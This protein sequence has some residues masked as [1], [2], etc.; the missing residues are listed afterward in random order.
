MAL[1]FNG[2]SA[3]LERAGALATAHPVTLFAWIKPTSNSTTRGVL[4]VGASGTTKY[5]ALI[6]VSGTTV[7]AQTGN[8]GGSS[9][10]AAI[11]GLLT[12]WQPVLARFSAINSR[13]VGRGA[14]T[15]VGGSSTIDSEISTHDLFR[16]GDWTSSASRIWFAG[17]IAE[18]AAW[19]I[20]LTQADYDALAAGA[21]PETIQPGSLIDV[22][23][24]ETQAS[25]QVGIV[26][27]L[28]LTATDTSQ[29]SDHPITRSGG[30]AGVTL[31]GIASAEAFGAL[32]FSTGAAGVVLT[33][34]ASAEAFGSLSVSAGVTGQVALT[35]IASTE[36]F[37]SPAVGGYG[38]D[39]SYE[40]R[41]SAMG[42]TATWPRAAF[43][44]G[45]TYAG[46]V[47]TSNGSIG[48]T[49]IDHNGGDAI[50]T[51][52]I[53]ASFQNNSHACPSVHFLPDNR[54]ICLYSMHND[55]TGLRYNISTNPLD[56]SAW[57]A[58]GVMTAGG[59]VAY[60]VMHYLATP[61]KYFVHY[62]VSVINTRCRATADFSTWDT[63]RVWISNASER[64]YVLSCSNNIDRI[65]FFFSSGHPDEVSNCSMYHAYLTVDAVGTEVWHKSD[66][67]VIT[68]PATPANATLVY[69]GSTVKGWNPEIVYGPDGNPW[70]LWQTYETLG[71]DH[72]HRFARW[73]GSAWISAQI[74]QTGGSR[75]S[76]YSVYAD[77]YAC[78]DGHNPSVVYA[79]VHVGPSKRIQE[80]R[81]RDNGATWGFE[82]DLSST[83]GTAYSAYLP[84]SPKG[85]DGRAAA[86][87]FYGDATTTISVRASV[88][89]LAEVTLTDRTGA[90][91]AA[92]L[93]GLDYA[94]F[95]AA[96]PGAA[97]MLLANGDGASTDASGTLTVATPGADTADVF[98][99][100]TDSGGDSAA[101]SN[102][103]AGP[104]AVV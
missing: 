94:V 10:N 12:S 66:G 65:D 20:D 90:T 63:E 31:T 26:S 79:S 53:A 87:F 36:A 71:S 44:N 50:T 1:T 80:W 98:V 57:G 101:D 47:A 52:I 70:V 103:F 67:T 3:K 56:I 74:C 25:T 76:T 19:S 84:S 93:T 104:V 73:T 92:G 97:T 54:L 64:P 95:D 82:K 55:A 7:R 42:T 5:E 37:G 61:G 32:S 51:A 2:T 23:P 38:V 21:L 17:D 75:D 58:Q 33:G 27:G 89:D 60:N 59:A 68:G 16:V 69:D 96:T 14:N 22:W 30:A 6:T 45:A 13:A 91:P 49:K 102:A 29:A 88:G 81:T 35:G 85:H 78:F 4:S 72:R 99:V 100:V 62:R 48:I 39:R 77:G 46:W 24:C 83:P 40:V 8:S 15:L 41:A 43:K 86:V 28:V 34:I 9:T 18:V 11:T